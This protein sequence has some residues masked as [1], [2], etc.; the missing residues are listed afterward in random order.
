M[1]YWL[2]DLSDDF[3][4]L[5]ETPPAAV[6]YHIIERKPMSMINFFLLKKDTSLSNKSKAA[7]KQ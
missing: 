4:G 6:V 2:A 3:A 1:T 7:L 5:I